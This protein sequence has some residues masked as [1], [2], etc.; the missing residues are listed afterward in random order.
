MG[1]SGEGH[2]FVNSRGT[3]GFKHVFL[4]PKAWGKTV[5]FVA[6]LGYGEDFMGQEQ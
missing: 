2:P 1:L 5:F 6:T 3:L 4:C